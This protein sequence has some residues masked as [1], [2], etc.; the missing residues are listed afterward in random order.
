MKVHGSDSAVPPSLVLGIAAR[1]DNMFRAAPLAPGSK[2]ALGSPE[3]GT[4]AVSSGSKM[5]KRFAYAVFER[6]GRCKLRAAKFKA[7]Q[8]DHHRDRFKV[9][10]V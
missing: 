1:K 9:S 4:A 3:A 6:S 8:V 10:A 5:N 7:R 2:L